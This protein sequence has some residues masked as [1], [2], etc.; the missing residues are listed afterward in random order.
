MERNDHW[1]SLDIEPK[2]TLIVLVVFRIV[3]RGIEHGR[4]PGN[5]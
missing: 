3:I 2:A 4:T 1:M 5:G